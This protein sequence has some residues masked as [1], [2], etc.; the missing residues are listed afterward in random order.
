MDVGEF[1]AFEGLKVE[2]VWVWS[3]LRLVFDLGPPGKPGTYIDVTVFHFTDPQGE[4]HA[5]DIELDPV[6][7]GVVLGVL[8]R[9]VTKARVREWQLTLEFDDGARFVCPPHDRWEAWQAQ[10]PEARTAI[11][12][13][14][15]GG[16][17]S[18]D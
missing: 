18:P 15:G 5:L 11:Y 1:S 3:S 13:P 10:L 6:A 8:H 9:R 2:Q 4:S 14:P 16:P 7:A 12:C 17:G